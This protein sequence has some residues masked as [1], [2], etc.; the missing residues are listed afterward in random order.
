[1]RIERTI[2]RVRKTVTR[3]RCHQ[4]ILFLIAW[5][6]FLFCATRAQEVSAYTLSATTPNTQGYV[7]QMPRQDDYPSGTPVKLYAGARQGYRFTGWT[8]NVPAGQEMKNPLIV[9]MDSSKVLTATFWTEGV[10]PG[11]VLAWGVNNNNQ[12]NV[13]S[14]NRDFVA[15]AS[16]YNHNLGLK[17]DGSLVPWGEASYGLNIVP[18]PNRDFVQVATGGYHNLGLKTDGAIVAWGSN[19]LGQCNVPMPNSNFV[20][21]AAGVEHSL[22][23]KSDGSVVTWGRTNEGQGNISLPNSGYVS[24]AAGWHNN[25]ALRYDGTVT[26]WGDMGFGSSLVPIPNEGFV[27]I[28]CGVHQALALKSDNTMIVWG[29]SDYGQ[30]VLPSPNANFEAIAGGRFHSMALNHN[31]IISVWGTNDTGQCNIPFPNEQYTQIAAGWQHS[32]GLKPIGDLVVNVSPADCVSSGAQWRLETELSSVWH[33]SGA[34]VT[35]PVGNYVVEYKD[36]DGWM[37][38]TTRTVTILDREVTVVNTTYSSAFIL[39]VNSLSGI[40]LRNPAQLGYSGGTTVTLTAKPQRWAMFDR[41]SGNVPQGQERSNPLNISMDANKSIEAH[42]KILWDGPQEIFGNCN[43]HGEKNVSTSND[44]FVMV[45]GTEHAFAGL[46]SDGRVYAWG[47]NYHGRVS[48]VPN[49]PADIVSISF[50]YVFGSALKSDGTIKIWGINDSTIRTVPGPNAGFIGVASGS[51]HVLALKVDGSIVTWGNN[52]NGQCNVPYPNRA[53]T[54][55]SAGFAHSLGLKS[56]G[57]IVAWGDNGQCN[58]PPPNNGFVA[59]AAGYAHSMG[60]KYDGSIVVWGNNGSGQYYVPSPN[61][62]FVEI[63]ANS[64]A[65]HCIG[66]KAN[67]SIVSWGRNESNQCPSPVDNSGYAGAG[68]ANTHSALIKVGQAPPV[69][70]SNLSPSSNESTLTPNLVSSAF[71]DWNIEDTHSASQW[72]MRSISSPADWSVTVFDSSTDTVNLTSIPVPTGVLDYTTTYVWRVRHSDNHGAWSI[73]SEPTQFKTISTTLYTLTIVSDPVNGGTVSKS[74]D[75]M[76]YTNGTQVTLTAVATNGF[77]FRG[78]MDGATT[79]STNASY[80]YTVAGSNKTFTAKFKA[81][82]TAQYTVNISENPPNSGT[83][84]KSPNQPTYTQDSQVTLTATPAGGYYF[85]GWTGDVLAGH[86]GNN[87]LVLTMDSNKT[88][89]ANFEPLSSVPV[90]SAFSI[91]NGVAVTANPT[92]ILPNTCVGTANPVAVQYMASESPDFSG[93]TWKSYA[94]VPIFTLSSGSGVK[95]VY[96][97]VKNSEGVESTVASDIITLG[98]PGYSIVA[99][100]RE[101]QGQCDVPVPN[102]D[103]V[104]L[105]AGFQHSLGLKSDGTVVAWGWNTEGQCNVPVD[106]NSDFVAIEAGGF[107]LGLKS[108]GSI[109]AWGDNY[110][111]RCNVPA[112]NSGFVAIAAGANHGLGLKSDGS[113][114]AWG[115]NPDGRCTVPSPNSDFVA[116]AAGW[117]QSLGLKS[118]GSVVV[119]GSTGSNVP[120]PNSEFVAIAGGTSHNMGLKSNGSIVV[121]GNNSY[122]QCNVPA[123]NNNFKALS[124]GW[125]HSLGLKLDGSI[126]A[127]GQDLDGQCNV[128]PPNNGFVTL[129]AGSYHSMALA[130]DTVPVEKYVLDLTVIPTDSGSVT[131]NPQPINGKYAKDTV[132]TL[133]AMPAEGYYFTGWTGDV[134]A[135]HEGNNPLV[136][137]MDSNKTIG[138]NFEPLSSVPVISAFSINNGVAITANPTVILPNT[139]VG[140]ANP[141]AVQYMASESPDFAGST[142]KSYAPVPIF[143]LSSGG[144]VK[145]VYFKVKNSEGVE[146]SVA[147][148]TINLGGPGYSI[149]AWGRN[150]SGQSD[151]PSTN[152]D[153]VAV[154]GGQYHSL[155]LKSDGSI[156][157]W[158][159]NDY[160]QC[161][162]PAPN[163]DFFAVA[164]GK[165]YHSLG[166][167]SDG[168]IVTWGSNIFGEGDSVPSPNSDF[169]AVAAGDWHNLG[170]KFDGSIVAWGSNSFGQCD[171][172]SPNSGFVAVAGGAGHSLGLKMDGSI[173]AWGYNSDGRCNVPSPNSNFVDVAAGDWHSM[174]LKSDGSIVAWGY[175][176]DGQCTVPSPNSGFVALSGGGEHSL[177]LKSDGSIVAWGKRTDYGQ[178][179]IPTPNSGFL[180]VVAGR[181]HSMA[182]VGDTVPGEK[183][184]LDLTVIPTNSGL[185]T[186]NPQPTNGKYAKD[187]VVTLTETPAAGYHFTGWTGDANGLTNPLVVAMDSSKNITANFAISEGDLAVMLTPPEAI[188]AGARWRLTDEKAGVWHDDTVYDPVSQTSSTV[189]RSPIGIHTLTFKEIAGW[190]KPV[191]QQVELTTDETTFAVGNYIKVWSLL[192]LYNNGTVS[193]SPSGTILSDGTTV[194]LTATPADGYHFTGWTGDITTST[195]PLVLTMDSNKTLMAHFVVYTGLPAPEN[196]TAV[197]NTYR[198]LV[199]WQAVPGAVGYEV[200]R[201]IAVTTDTTPVVWT[202]GE[203]TEFA[204]DTAVPGVTYEYQVTAIDAQ[205]QPGTASD[206]VAATV[207]LKTFVSTT[208]KVTAKGYTMVRNAPTT[209]NLTFTPSVPDGVPGTIKITRLTKVPA[210]LAEDPAKGIYYLTNQSQAPVLKI[211]GDV[212]TL[213]FDVPVN[214][215]EVTG[216]VNAVQAKDE[217]AFIQVGEMASAKIAATRPMESGQYARTFIETN[218]STPLTLQTTGV[219]VESLG[220][221]FGAGQPVKLLSTASK[222]YKNSVGLTKTSL[223]AIGSLPRVVAEVMGIPAPQSEATPCSIQ[224]NM[225]KSVTVSGGPIVADEMIGLI[226]KV[227]VSGG[228]LRCGLIQS[229]KDLVLL[230]ATAK[231]VNG[232]L[233]GGA[234]GTAAKPGEML[235]QAQPNSKSMAIAKVS[236]QTGVSGIFHAGYDPT[237][238][239]PNY[240][241]GIAILQTKAPYVVEGAAFLDPALVTKMKVLP[242][243]PAQS[244]EINPVE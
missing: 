166:L 178:S 18:W 65:D 148:D 48:D 63:V 202:V 6:V 114:V 150:D 182:L 241:G 163:S 153:F 225:L 3:K 138:A 75:Q 186:Q 218:G 156:V 82:A 168:S 235:V 189:L 77:T 110:Y 90:I 109:V 207:I 159:S 74:P 234:V 181:D 108:D 32:I 51:S 87:P 201:T 145:T 102:S 52:G 174:G 211:A 58:V 206:A 229:S 22:G 127:W 232:V 130:G 88:I 213:A 227:T 143:T 9:T 113:I 215:L 98:G 41:W 190:R 68:L 220:S 132:V 205:G 24:I 137:T 216:A 171:V 4:R 121:W 56:D 81:L 17:T 64:N 99:W 72:Q 55:V 155:G 31:G 97:K 209:G 136:L 200:R 73:W 214:L 50:G 76:T 185:V 120:S 20:A 38:P 221:A 231:K 203:V 183:Y 5:G 140:T 7:V 115:D 85:T 135:G 197:V 11:M 172:P 196:V 149:V 217:V 212:K 86:E 34:T 59:I 243:T 139:C 12:C 44:K 154:A 236:G 10:L 169:V 158:G 94:P 122:G 67:G 175:S 27:A 91:N 134:L 28:E 240:K 157:A 116:I 226:D 238:G 37:E 129:A 106:N 23:L 14:P 101:T 204:D 25:L 93:S 60:L 16:K 96:F 141:V 13:P 117:D 46:K 80:V 112:P 124:G 95:T 118:D 70:P 47:D 21:V 180:S 36:I 162:V 152:S 147:S 84:S 43:D 49:L 191:D 57:T 233:V 210:N 222:S 53:F 79:V 78:W 170:L 35:L 2:A 69:Q 192:T 19:D 224:G 195:N 62:D 239:N 160:G 144:G 176:A 188:V 230:Q 161:D 103:F 71:I 61:K 105:A 151:I 199:G 128:P 193:T 83:V 33:D 194:T 146:S 173:V 237:T 89:G 187:T 104:A 119:W 30:G 228:N 244:I 208:Y 123:P 15:I 165:R 125:Q 242:K 126:V 42:Y 54:A 184:S 111:G 133:T 131:Q 29:S 100:G 198:V 92:V 177:G 142:W 219:V 167:K 66:I 45:T 8:G 39:N 164:A 26:G 179:T 223:G 1:M 40:V 107:S